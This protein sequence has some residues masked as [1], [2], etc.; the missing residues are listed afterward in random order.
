[1][2]KSYFTYWTRTAIGVP[3]TTNYFWRGG[4]VGGACLSAQ[5]IDGA[6][7]GSGNG[8][9]HVG[10]GEGDGHGTGDGRGYSSALATPVI[11][12]EAS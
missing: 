5:G 1:M 10:D 7:G 6:G 12:L 2:R 9:Y 4:G 11:T 8:A 3:Y